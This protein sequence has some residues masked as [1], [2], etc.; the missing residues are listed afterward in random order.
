MSKQRFPLVVVAAAVGALLIPGTAPAPPRA[1]ET[2][3]APC[4]KTGTSEEEVV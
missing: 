4:F 2:V 1:A 3:A